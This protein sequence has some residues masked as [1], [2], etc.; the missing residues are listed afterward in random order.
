MT[1]PLY[2]LLNGGKQPANNP[3]TM[4]QRFNEF[5]QSFTGDPEQMVKQLLQSGRM[6]Q[7]DFNKLQQ[8]AQEFM[9]YLPKN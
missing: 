9:K 3:L 4:L 8:M 1:N 5:R 2:Q 7:Q 6:S